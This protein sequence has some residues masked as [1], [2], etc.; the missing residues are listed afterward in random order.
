MHLCY[1]DESGTSDIPGNSAY[2]VLAGISIPIWHWG[3]CDAEVTQVKMRFGLQNA[4]LHTAWMLRRYPEQESITGFEAMNYVQRR[5][6]VEIERRKRIHALQRSNPK[7]LKQT[8]KNFVKTNAYTHLT[9]AERQRMVREVAEV[10]GNWGFARLFGEAVD[11]ANYMPTD[12][13]WTPEVQ[14]FEQVVSRFERFLTNVSQPTQGGKAYGLLIHDNNQTVC[15]AHTN[16]MK[17]FHS[18]GTFFTAVNHI[19]ETPL[20]VDSSLTGMVQIADLCAYAIRRYYENSEE[21]LLDLILPRADRARGRIVG[22]RHYTP[23][24]CA[25]KICG[26]RGRDGGNGTDRDTQESPVP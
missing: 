3:G 21:E 19:I 18:Q 2:F 26:G 20:F 4:E 17:R 6:S 9:L 7:A 24:G 16:L 11:K 22:L 25:C 23:A 14:A 13:T 8:K 1:I 15:L 12:T 10:I 5:A